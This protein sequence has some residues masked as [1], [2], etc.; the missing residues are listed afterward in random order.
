MERIII[1]MDEVIADPMGDMVRWYEQQYGQQVNVDE[2]KEGSWVR[3]FPEQ[4]RSLILERLYS[5]GF[6][7]IS[8]SWRMHRMF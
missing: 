7:E 5:E 2:M 8:L 1:D 3:G 6:F 4:H